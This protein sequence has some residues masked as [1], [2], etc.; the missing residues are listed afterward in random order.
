MIL[1]GMKLA[2]IGMSIVYLFL[3]LLIALIVMTS[4]ILHE[5]TQKE[6]LSI[7]NVASRSRAA[8]HP[9]ADR[10]DHL[11]AVIGAAVTAHRHRMGRR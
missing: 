2:V 1:A 9:M 11:I 8:I 10:K 7:T 6:A 4:K 5:R 3:A